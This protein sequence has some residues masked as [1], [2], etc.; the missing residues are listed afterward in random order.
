M[1]ATALFRIVALRLSMENQIEVQTKNIEFKIL[2]WVEG[3][4]RFK[5]ARF[6]GFGVQGLGVQ[7]LRRLR[8]FTK[9][10]Q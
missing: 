1:E 10:R 5:G 9:T 6:K 7:E 3:C 2:V 4:W 8:V